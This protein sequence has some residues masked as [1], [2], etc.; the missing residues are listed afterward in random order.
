MGKGEM[1]IYSIALVL[2]IKKAKNIF[3]HDQ[4]SGYILS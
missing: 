2:Y 1:Q 4:M 3:A